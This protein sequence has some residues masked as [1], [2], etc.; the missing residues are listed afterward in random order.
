MA[1]LGGPRGVTS[2][3]IHAVFQNRLT[4]LQAQAKA[5]YLHAAEGSLRVWGLPEEL[6]TDLLNIAKLHLPAHDR[7]ELNSNF[8]KVTQ[9]TKTAGTTGDAISLSFQ[10]DYVASEERALRLRHSSLCRS[11]AHAAARRYGLATGNTFANIREQAE[12][13]IQAGGGAR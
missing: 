5:A 4:S 12:K 1:S 3:I 7:Q 8:E 2:A 13:M 9:S 11:L 6:R 10:T